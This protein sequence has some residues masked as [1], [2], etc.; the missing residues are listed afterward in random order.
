MSYRLLW[1]QQHVDGTDKLYACSTA[2][3]QFHQLSSSTQR[4]ASLTAWPHHRYAPAPAA[5][6]AVQ[7]L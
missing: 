5:A 7:L 4:L 6:P 2:L 1:Q 3:T